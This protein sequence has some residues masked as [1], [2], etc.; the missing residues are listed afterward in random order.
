MSLTQTYFELVLSCRR[1]L[2]SCFK[3]HGAGQW[4][5][6]D[7]RSNHKGKQAD[8]TDQSYEKLGI[9]NRLLK[10]EFV[11]FE[12]KFNAKKEYLCPLL[13]VSPNFL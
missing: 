13:S 3:C 6:Q 7:L 12:V 2:V 8:E 9:Q 5:F 11:A 10:R 1:K 4:E